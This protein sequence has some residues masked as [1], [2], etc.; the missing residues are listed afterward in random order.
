MSWPIKWEWKYLP[1]RF[2]DK[3][4]QHNV[5]KNIQHRAWCILSF[6]S[7]CYFQISWNFSNK[8]TIILFIKSALLKVPFFKVLCS[9]LSFFSHWNSRGTVIYSLFKTFFP[10]A[11]SLVICVP[12]TCLSL[13]SH[14]KLVPKIF[15]KQKLDGLKQ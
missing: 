15:C 10:F 5:H 4:K 1:Y 11:L 7:Y 2:V 6:D 14:S 12:W 3:I 13:Y 9:S 8:D